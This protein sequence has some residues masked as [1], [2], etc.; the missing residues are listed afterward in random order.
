MDNYLLAWLFVPQTSLLLKQH[1]NNRRIFGKCHLVSK[2]GPLLTLK[3]LLCS[4]FRSQC[5][6]E[7]YLLKCFVKI[8]KISGE[9]FLLTHVERKALRVE[10]LAETALHQKDSLLSIAK[11]VLR[12]YR[13][14]PISSE[15]KLFHIPTLKSKDVD[16]IFAINLH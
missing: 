9:S 12:C 15:A 14:L 4:H 1:S 11:T 6:V 16:S 2:Y 3:Y 5:I 10:R 8:T 13:D 7:V